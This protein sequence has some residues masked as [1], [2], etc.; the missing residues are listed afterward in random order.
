[1]CQGILAKYP[2]QEQVKAVLDYNPDTGDF[3]W[4]EN[5]FV[6]NKGS[7]LQ[8]VRYA[9]KKAGTVSSSGSKSYVRINCRSLVSH[10]MH[11][12]RLACIYMVGYAPEHVD[13]INGNG[14]DNR[15]CNLR[16]SDTKD[17]AKNVRKAS[18]NTSGVTGVSKVKGKEVWRAYI[19]INQK[20]IWLGHFKS[21]ADAAKARSEANKLFEFRDGHGSDRPLY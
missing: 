16:F 8:S 10:P 7:K 19:K 3:T 13:H 4:K 20:T 21:L 15:W 12:H 17:N 11:A 9:G 5:P 1:M 18:N 2:T 6:T 14:T